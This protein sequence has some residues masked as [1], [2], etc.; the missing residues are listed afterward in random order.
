VADIEVLVLAL[1]VHLVLKYYG[2]NLDPFHLSR[3]VMGSELEF[4]KSLWGLGIEEE[5]GYRT[6]PPGYIGWRNSFLGIDSRARIY[7]PSFHENKPKTLV[8]T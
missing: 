7:R 4:L 8:F 6:V 5:E 2:T 1:I 3:N